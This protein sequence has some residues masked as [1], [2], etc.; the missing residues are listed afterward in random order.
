VQNSALTSLMS[1]DSA[2][3]KS[4]GIP[5]ATAG[6][7]LEPSDVQ[8]P[9]RRFPRV[10][11]TPRCPA[12]IPEHPDEELWVDGPRSSICFT[13][14]AVSASW[15]QTS[16]LDKCANQSAKFTMQTT[17]STE[18]WVDGPA[19]FR[20]QLNDAVSD[21][22]T[23]GNQAAVARKPQINNDVEQTASSSR[24]SRRSA[25]SHGEAV[26][27]SRLPKT[28]S[29]KNHS[30]SSPRLRHSPQP[31][32]DGRITAWVKSVQQA[33]HHPEADLHQS[34]TFNLAESQE[35]QETGS[36][37]VKDKENAENVEPL[38]K[39]E[40]GSMVESSHSLYEHQVDESLE[41]ASQCGNA[42][43]SS[44]EDAVSLL[45]CKVGQLRDGVPDGCADDKL[46]TELQITATNEN[47]PLTSV[48][49]NVLKTP[50]LSSGTSRK[51]RQTELVVRSA[52]NCSRHDNSSP[53][54]QRSASFPR[55]NSSLHGSPSP[56]PSRLRFPSTTKTSTPTSVHRSSNTVHERSG[57][58][59]IANCA[60]ASDK[61]PANVSSQKSQKSMNPKSQQSKSGGPR[62]VDRSHPSV[63]KSSPTSAKVERKS[64]LPVAAKKTSEA[65]S[66][67]CLVSPYHTVT[68]PRRRAAGCSTS[69]DNSSLLSDAVTARSKS[70]EVELSSGYESML[71]DDSDEMITGHCTDDWT[72]DAD[73]T[74]GE[75]TNSP[76]ALTC[77]KY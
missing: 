15:T 19:E 60:A 11:M 10:S 71:R 29:S 4:P 73:H 44:D 64:C 16:S 48:A 53:A 76:K 50:V 21:S 74:P 52:S 38:E 13:P 69:S 40:T 18:L 35:L 23:A 49:D 77:G 62:S 59:H 41:T 26:S 25:A 65:G 39:E 1:R 66:G 6:A 27:K 37:E 75:Y 31:V 32:L 57:V 70:S 45:N 3:R 2:H 28:S 56:Q 58:K 46:F 55:K 51:S 67:H 22:R 61:I 7:E 34:C 63:A 54:S 42:L 36:V 33:S 47:I 30:H 72:A 20:T 17:P 14:A 43:M 12:T 9:R 24:L 8:S 5:T 68:S